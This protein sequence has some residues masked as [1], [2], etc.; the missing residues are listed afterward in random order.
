MF[1][2]GMVNRSPAPVELL[3]PIRIAG[4]PVLVLP[5]R[6]IDIAIVQQ[7]PDFLAEALPNS[8]VDPVACVELHQG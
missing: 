1:A 8:T 5:E 6:V 7:Q 4:H 2:Q 3:L